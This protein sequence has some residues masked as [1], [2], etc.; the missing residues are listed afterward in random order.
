M[1]CQSRRR[2]RRRYLSPPT[3]GV[4]IEMGLNGGYLL[5]KLSP[6]TRG[7]WI[8]I[9]MISL[10]LTAEYVTPHAGGGD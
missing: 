10:T 7:V 9:L 1:K 2:T 5:Q 3:R 8:E 6:P 4:W